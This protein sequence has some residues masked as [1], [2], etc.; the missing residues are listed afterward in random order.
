MDVSHR[1]MQDSLVA[2]CHVPVMQED[3]GCSYGHKL[4][5]AGRIATGIDQWSH[6]G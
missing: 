6:L 3:G 1:K 2:E 5:P 4:S